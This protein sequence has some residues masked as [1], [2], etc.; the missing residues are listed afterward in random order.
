[1]SITKYAPEDI[2]YLTER[3][4]KLEFEL[5]AL[6]VEKKAHHT[7]VKNGVFKCID[8]S[9][10]DRVKLGKMSDGVYGIIIKDSDEDTVIEVTDEHI[11]VG[12][13]VITVKI[14]GSG[15]DTADGDILFDSLTIPALK[16]VLIIVAPKTA[17]EDIYTNAIRSY[18]AGYPVCGIPVIGGVLATNFQELTIYP[19][20]IDG[21]PSYPNNKTTWEMGEYS[22]IKLYARY[23]WY[24][25]GTDK[26]WES[27]GSASWIA[28]EIDA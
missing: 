12:E 8:S 18:Q 5:K 1:M 19:S 24:A 20:M 17:E 27:G 25:T 6:K 10:K 15:L 26:Y 2:S 9:G 16:K 23:S 28:L 14:V 13:T 7:S 4:S 11:I 21:K 22:N 3:I